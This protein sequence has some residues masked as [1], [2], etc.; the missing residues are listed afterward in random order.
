MHV[1]IFLSFTAACFALVGGAAAQ[2]PQTREA[3]LLRVIERL[4]Q[5]L[6]ELE[7]KVERLERGNAPASEAPLGILGDRI[8]KLEQ[9]AGE[10]A[11]A[12]ND[13]RVY[14]NK[15]L[16]MET[17]DEQFKF[18][19]GGRIHIDHAWFDQD[20]E[21]D[22]V[23]DWDAAA[24]RRLNVE[25]GAEFRFA[26]LHVKGLAYGNIEFQAEYDFAGG[27]AEMKDTYIAY[28]GIPHV[29]DIWVGH[30][31][32]PFSLVEL[33]SDNNITFMERSLANA[34]VPSRNM[35]IAIKNTLWDERMTY[36]LGVFRD[37]DDSGTGLN[38][39]GYAFTGRL[40]GLPWRNDDRSALVHLGASYS[41]R[42]TND[43]VRFDARPEAHL[44]NW[45]FVDTGDFRA[46]EIRLWGAELAG[47]Y[48]PLAFQ[49]EWI[50]A[51]TDAGFRG[52]PQ[53][54]G[55]YAQASYVLTGESLEYLAD[56]GIFGSITAS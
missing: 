11:P 27:D 55:W 18:S 34:L 35:G 41:W 7:T 24:P 44:S 1:T 36:A 4:E 22:Y 29:G 54:G 30:Y 5:R 13:F 19:V 20:D 16:R 25:N 10:S 42:D 3:E 53:F 17:R 28:L 47:K 48:G 31:K 40:T 52:N 9:Q 51:E 12:P 38:D 6:D 46:E 49:T 26:R 8:S 39:G 14:W 43:I 50:G 45:R 23:L 15:G 2:E 56:E 37:T 32:E 33:Q 21:L